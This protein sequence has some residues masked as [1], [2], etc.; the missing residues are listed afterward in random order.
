MFVGTMRNA[1]T[2]EYKKGKLTKEY[3]KDKKRWEEIDKKSEKK[4][5][6]NSASVRP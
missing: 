4:S 6:R 2:K 1:L 3:R 5:T